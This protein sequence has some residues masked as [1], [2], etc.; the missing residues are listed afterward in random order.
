M[1][2]PTPICLKLLRH[3]VRLASSFRPAKASSSR[4]A[5]IAIIAMTNSNSMSVNVKIAD[6]RRYSIAPAAIYP[7]PINADYYGRFGMR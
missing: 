1:V 2:M 3:W 4:A 5:R 7:S 6:C